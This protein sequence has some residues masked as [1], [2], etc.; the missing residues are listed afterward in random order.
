MSET[1]LTVDEW[2]TNLC[3]ENR[4][5]V[6][7]L[8]K[9]G[10]DRGLRRLAVDK[11][12]DPVHFVYEL[13]QNAE[14]QDATRVRFDL[15]PDRLLFWHNGNPFCRRDVESITG[16]GD[17]DK[18]LSEEVK[19]GRF[20][21]GFKSVFS[22][23]ERPEVYSTIDGEPFSF[24]IED[25][26]VPTPQRDTCGYCQKGGTLFVL[27][28]KDA[29]RD[30]IY[31][32]IQTRL[33]LLGADTLLFLDD[34][35]EIGWETDGEEGTYLC[36][37]ESVA[38]ENNNGARCVLL[39]EAGLR[40]G[41]KRREEMEYLVFARAV[42]ITDKAIDR[43]LKVQIAFRVENGRIVPEPGQ[44]VVNVYFPTEEKSELRFRLHAPFLLT[45][46]R[47]NIK[48]GEQFN[49][50]LMDIAAS[51]LIDS[52]TPLKQQGLLDTACLGVLPLYTYTKYE[53]LSDQFTS[54][55]EPFFKKTHDAFAN[56]S[57]LPTEHGSH[58]KAGEALIS[59]SSAIRDL[60]SERQ[61][62]TLFGSGDGP[63][64]RCWL[65]PDITEDRMPDVRR[66]LLKLGITEVDPDF[67]A[68]RVTPKFLSE[69][70]DKWMVS[71][72]AF[73]G[74]QEGL[75]GK[76]RYRPILRTR[77]IIR[78]EGGLHV[79]P[80]KEDGVTPNAYL[81]PEGR[82]TPLPI[83]KRDI[84]AIPDCHTFFTRLGLSEPDAVG[85]VI[86]S[87][88]PS[89]KQTAAYRANSVQI[90]E[91]LYATRLR[92]IA[93]AIK[94]CP[95]AKLEPLLKHL[96]NTAFVLAQ[97][98][99]DADHLVFKKLAE[100]CAE[101]SDLRL[102]FGDNPEAWFPATILTA[103][104]DWSAIASALAAH[105]HV[106][107]N[108]V[109]IKHRPASH[110]NM[111]RLYSSPRDHM[112]GLN[113][114]DPWATIDGL[115]HALATITID[116][117]KFL[118]RLLL[119]N[120]E[121]LR[122]SVETATRENF[123]NGKIEGPKFSTFGRQ[124]VES[125]WLPIVDGQFRKPAEIA[126]DQLADEAGFDRESV[127]AKALARQLGMKQSKA[128]V[129]A[130]RLG[131]D[132]RAL[133]EFLSLTKEEWKAAWEVVANRRRENTTTDLP[134]KPIFPSS[135]SPNPE[136]RADKMRAYA[137]EADD[138]AFGKVERSVRYSA[139]HIAEDTDTYLR[140]L[141]VNEEGIMVCQICQDSMPFRRDD[142]EWYFEHVQCVRD[143]VQKEL[144]PNYLA[145]C[146]ICA[147]MYKVVNHTE[148]ND[149]VEAILTYPVIGA[150][151]EGKT[152]AIAIN[153]VLGGE[154][155]SI[156]FVADHFSDLQAILSEETIVEGPA[157]TVMA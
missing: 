62:A 121:L 113:G 130:E 110:D 128:F 73:L 133:S 23:T 89:F 74:E 58:V 15:R 53:H 112:R 100:V 31:E 32:N 41:K 94:E 134:P 7:G 72:Y 78:L 131:V 47:A 124:C 64:R 46:N 36:D 86:E 59:R 24:A 125:E 95:Q 138:R 21:I 50:D 19:I 157:T 122:G 116:K 98:A 77:P 61:L 123:T 10:W 20:G 139:G 107:I 28:F 91:A 30:A 140:R 37:R 132:E 26:F 118:W 52:L 75:W 79:V 144:Y 90:D 49:A 97:R 120:P 153:I 135:S 82:S 145:L 8:K 48:R 136:R 88:L 93:S 55:F 114:F 71:F 29:D 44:N 141:Y 102:W 81:P 60:L 1:E 65:S 17:S 42:E 149:V 43:S 54:M 152:Q 147:A 2:F 108:R 106:S 83:V 3:E 156:R 76:G 11:Y 99:T 143:I 27:P 56:Q 5:L 34:I 25:I 103:N 66:F 137:Q 115:D 87:I 111:V 151:D 96:A 67:F 6:D 80:F 4:S 129:F 119:R 16:L 150:A 12:P 14:D 18:P 85:D 146:P 63:K 105:G 84:D 117:A 126:L 22:V 101:T 69:Q 45:D 109:A 51:L 35:I 104:P 148:P 70:T 57:L 142:G 38:T 92:V 39:G 127:H 40:D 13:L 155:H 154:R 9:K 33:Q 68:T